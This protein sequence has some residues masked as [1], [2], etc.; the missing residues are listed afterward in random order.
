M[1]SLIQFSLAIVACW[2]LA[3]ERSAAQ[4]NSLYTNRLLNG[5][6]NRNSASA[7]TSQRFQNRVLNRV[8][9]TYNFSNVNRNVLDGARGR[10]KP[11]ANYSSPSP[12]SPY[13]ALDQP[14]QN[15]ST[16][17]YTQI[18]PMQEQQRLNQQVAQRSAAIQQQ[19]NAIAAQGPYSPQGDQERAPTGHTATFMNHGGYYQ[20]PAPRF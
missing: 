15:T 9:P 18:R 3:P 13:L 19:L 14:F 17:Y 12:V 8:V 7:F 11:F 2:A 1:K 20:M 10:A 6:Q 16:T 5:N 4:D